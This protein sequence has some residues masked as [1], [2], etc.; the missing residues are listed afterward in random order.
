MFLKQ[1]ENPEMFLTQSRFVAGLHW[2]CTW[3]SDVSEA[4]RFGKEEADSI[5]ENLLEPAEVVEEQFGCVF[6][7]VIRKIIVDK[8]T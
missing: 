1:E 2:H 4:T 6:S 8:N 5:V 3:V 7:F